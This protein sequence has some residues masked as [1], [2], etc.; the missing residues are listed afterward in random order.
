MFSEREQ[1]VNIIRSTFLAEILY[2]LAFLFAIFALCKI[3]TS[4]KIDVAY[5][6]K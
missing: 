1:S 2:Q 5:E 6:I 3:R 4:E